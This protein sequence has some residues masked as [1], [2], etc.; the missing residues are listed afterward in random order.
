[1]DLFEIAAQWVLGSLPSDGLPALATRCMED[2]MDSESLRRLAGLL[3]SETTDARRLFQRALTELKAP[4]LDIAEATRILTVK[5]SRQIVQG[6]LT[7]E[8]GANMIMHLSFQVSSKIGNFHDL[9]PFVYAA[10]E[11]QSRPDDREIY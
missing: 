9:D 4:V 7:P 6:E 11:L 1:M 5:F 3:P 2:G 10:S 8:E